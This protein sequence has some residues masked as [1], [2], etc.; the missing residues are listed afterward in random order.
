MEV[1][2]K[3]APEQPLPQIT[4]PHPQSNPEHQPT[5]NETDKAIRPPSPVLFREPKAKAFNDPTKPSSFA[6][7]EFKPADQRV[8]VL[9]DDLLK[10]YNIQTGNSHQKNHVSGTI[11]KHFVND[12]LFD[13]QFYSSR[14]KGA[15][16]NPNK[17]DEYI[18]ERL[19]KR[20]HISQH[21]QQLLKDAENPQVDSVNKKLKESRLTV[22]DPERPDF[23]GPW[24]PYKHEL[25]FLNGKIID[26]KNLA[27]PKNEFFLKDKPQAKFP[28][29][30]DPYYP[31]RKPHDVADTNF[32]GTSTFHLESRT[33]Y[34]GES[35]ILPP[36][37]KALKDLTKNIIPTTPLH[38]YRGHTKEIS[39]AKFFPKYGHFILSASF[40]TT[41]KLWDVYNT[42]TVVQTYNGHSAAV[43]DI[44]FNND[45]THFLSAGFDARIRFWDTEYGKVVT[46][47]NVQKHPY[48]VRINPDEDR[49]NLFLNASMNSKI[50]QYDLRTTEKVVQYDDHS[51]PVNSLLFV[52]N[53]KKFV[54]CG[55]D[56]KILMWEFGVPVIIRN[57]ND[58]NIQS[59]T[60]TSL[61]P[62]QDYFAAQTADN[63]VV[64]FD[65]KAS[66]LRVV[67]GKKFMGH[68][69]AG[70][71][72]GTTFT[73][74]GK[75]LFSG[76]QDGRIFSWDWKTAAPVQVFKAHNNV[77]IGIDWHPNEP[78][79]MLSC[80][81][82]KTI[83]L[84][85]K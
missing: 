40:D 7:A 57:I 6:L 68:F 74:N 85:T 42:R 8:A 60:T 22:N 61:H 34:Q 14:N 81:W 82:D 12:Q 65:V 51:G 43:K 80:S 77:C 30:M 32:E 78:A 21:E 28:G 23:L 29:E 4:D 1:A 56:K 79:M 76:D 84:W 37:D 62:S 75:Y 11:E 9:N 24:A 48:C 33:N 27:N 45:G 71:A 59:I 19:G 72:I 10:Q 66:S 38:V 17:S 3:K 41:V 36:K 64:V 13:E 18:L 35:F 2:D 58:S 67:R 47:F 39:V 53:N 15:Y 63:K 69:S 73:P 20:V 44:C 54:S 55:D 31:P 25:P 46:T 26:T 52:D 16:A 49:Q 70:Y 83:K 5:R 50:E